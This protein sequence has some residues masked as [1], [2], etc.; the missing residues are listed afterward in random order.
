MMKKL[1][2]LLSAFTFLLFSAKA[3]D[4][5]VWNGNGG[6]QNWDNPDNWDNGV[7]T[8]ALNVQ[9]GTSPGP[10]ILNGT[11]AETNILI[12]SGTGVTLEIQSTGSLT[13]NGI[14]DVLSNGTLDVNGT[15]TF[16]DSFTV[17]NSGNVS[18]DTQG[19]VGIGGDLTVFSGSSFTLN[20]GTL[21]IAGSLDVTGTGSTF[22]NA[23]GQVNVGATTK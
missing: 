10:I 16:L 6:D 15:I 4:G 12:I 18:I 13:C 20:Q 8:A 19:S 2:L 23:A 9:I 5:T 14:A 3:Q 1:L 21:N 7:P 11:S 17:Q 22:N